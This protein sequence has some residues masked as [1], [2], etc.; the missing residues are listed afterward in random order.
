M[1]RFQT[2]GPLSLTATEDYEGGVF[3]VLP[4]FL[5][6]ATVAGLMAAGYM[7][8]S[9]PLER[10]PIDMCLKGNFNQ[11]DIAGTGLGQDLP[12]C[13]SLNNGEAPYNELDVSDS[14]ETLTHDAED[15]AQ[16]GSIFRP[17]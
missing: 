1:S 4:K 14:G 12:T 10:P 9:T 7:V 13:G 17:G 11:T 5:I 3:K 8:V 6:G 2:D 16:L 15:A